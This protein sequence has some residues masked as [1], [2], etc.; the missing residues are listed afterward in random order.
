MND[1]LFLEDEFAVFMVLPRVIA[2]LAIATFHG[3]ALFLAVSA[4]FAL[5]YFM[6][7]TSVVVLRASLAM[8]DVVLHVNL[9]PTFENCFHLDVFL[10]IL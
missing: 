9:D 1:I 4:V 5:A 7:G 10:V 6:T 8:S 2:H 3:R